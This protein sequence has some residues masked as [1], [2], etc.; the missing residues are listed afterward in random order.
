MRFVIIGVSLFSLLCGLLVAGIAPAYASERLKVGLALSGGGSRGAAHIGVLREL[1]RMRIPIDYI[2]GTSVGS[3]IGGLYA[4]G[5]GVDEIENI[6]TRSNIDEIF[7]DHQARKDMSIRRKVD[8]RVFQLDKE[9]GI[10]KDAEGSRKIHLPS[11]LKQGQKLS[12]FLDKLFLPVADIDNF[13]LFPIP[14]RAVAT[15]ISS[16]EVVVLGGGNITTAIRASMSVPA[17]FS[18][19]ELDGRILVDGG[20]SNNLPVDVVR[21]MGADVV[22]AV[23]IGSHLI[24]R[25]KLSNALEISLQLT[26]ILVRRTTAEQIALLTAGDILIQP[27]LQGYSSIDFKDAAQLIPEGE[28]VTQTRE[29]ELTRL[30]LSEKR[31]EQHFLSRETRHESSLPVIAFIEVDNDTALADAFILAKI[32]QPIDEA[33]DFDQLERDIS[34]L[35]GMGIFKSVDYSVVHKGG[36]SGLQI[37]ARQ[38]PWGPNYLE[39]GFSYSS[40]LAS[41][42]NL[43][44]KLGYTVTPT[45]ARN[46]EWRS[47]IG[48][49]VERGILTE[50]HQPLSIDS[51]YYVNG[52]L[53]LSSRLFNE[54]S[55]EQKISTTRVE[56]LRASLSVGREYD[57]WGDARLSVN[58]YSSDADLETGV[59]INPIEG[60]RG[61]EIEARFLSDTLD[62]TFFPSEGLRS[63]LRWISS[64]D[65]LGADY[66]FEKG[67]V[68][69]LGVTTFAG[70]HSVFLGGRFGSTYS[71]SAPV[72]NGFR[73]GG[74]FNLPGFTDRELSGQNVYLLRT[75]YQRKLKERFGVP[76]YA[77]VTLQYGDISASR[78]ELSLNDGITSL[79]VWGGWKTIIGPVFLGYGRA[80]T[81]RDSFYLNVGAHF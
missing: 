10:K 24:S 59:P 48:L 75:A 19:V 73:L 52:R 36:Q 61:G 5:M 14:F 62:H 20:I 8:H 32:E 54:F 30:A 39:F 45:N 56:E 71:G 66:E 2:A 40:D 28:S 4:S 63:Q 13:D 31:F 9:L 16:S 68:D 22:I 60:V 72:Q 42:N 51:P 15:D 37:R 26:S 69:V 6:I 11:G 78:D 25:Q 12:L 79:A 49:G 64:R 55:G 7:K 18:A 77:G 27:D 41:D 81:G 80:D 35:H 53:A 34:V 1:E 21:S 67:L 74:L 47:A 38:K 65:G 3:I 17:I 33:L 43:S 76:H 23:D 29:H 58:Q 70:K 50:Y 57:N 44:F 46:G